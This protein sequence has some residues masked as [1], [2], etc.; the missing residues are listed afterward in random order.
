VKYRLTV[1][2]TNKSAWITDEY[3]R[4]KAGW[5]G[6]TRRSAEQKAKN[7]GW[8]LVGRWELTSPPDGHWRPVE[9]PWWRR[10]FS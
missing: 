9:K 4:T 10:I 2:Q 1:D 8:R 3:G 7:A 5:S 6:V